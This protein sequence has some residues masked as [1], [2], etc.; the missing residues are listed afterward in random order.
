MPSGCSDV[1]VHPGAPTCRI[2]FDPLATPNR[3]KST[4]SP[5]GPNAERHMGATGTC[6]LRARQ[7]ATRVARATHAGLQTGPG[8]DASAP[9]AAV[10]FCV[11]RWR[12]F[13]VL[14]SV[15]AADARRAGAAAGRPSCP[16]WRGMGFRSFVGVGRWKFFVFENERDFVFFVQCW[17]WKFSATN[18]SN[19]KYEVEFHCIFFFFLIIILTNTI[20]YK[21]L[22]SCK[23]YCR[24]Y[25]PH[26]INKINRICQLLSDVLHV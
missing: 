19:L 2:I 21:E 4:P 18:Q 20:I 9:V 23:I 7:T 24:F 1:G 16:C 10:F 26:R 11:F 25:F 6:V 17:I 15:A 5:C 22:I 3:G 12:V 13:A 14:C 8:E